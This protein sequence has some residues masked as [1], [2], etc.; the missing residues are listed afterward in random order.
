MKAFGIRLFLWLAALAL[1]LPWPVHSQ[2]GAGTALQFD[3]V[4]DQ[5]TASDASVWRLF[6]LTLTAWVKT[7]QNSAA[8]TGIAGNYAAQSANGYSLALRNGRVEAFI[9]ERLFHETF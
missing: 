8:Y 4:D 6:P 1:L 9:A 7:T 2:A 3:G 5:A